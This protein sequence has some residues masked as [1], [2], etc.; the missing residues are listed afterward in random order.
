MGPGAV[1]AVHGALTDDVAFDGAEMGGVDVLG[2][3]VVVLVCGAGVAGYGEVLGA[4]SGTGP[5]HEGEIDGDLVRVGVL[6][7]QMFGRQDHA[8][9]TETAL[10]GSMFHKGFL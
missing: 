2:L 4:V 6:V 10:D 1:V 3:E 7:Q 5:G 8:G 9:G